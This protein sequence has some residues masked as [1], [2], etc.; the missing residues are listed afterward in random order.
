MKGASWAVLLVCLA[1][2]WGCRDQRRRPPRATVDATVVSPRRG[3][4][5]AAP[6]PVPS[7]PAQR[8]HDRLHRVSLAKIVHALDQLYVKSVALQG[9]GVSQPATQE[10]WPTARE[11]LVS[12]AGRVRAQVL[13]VDPLSNRSWAAARAIV[14]LRYLTVKLPDAIRE[15]WRAR[16]SGA[17]TT[18]KSDFRLIWSRLRRYVEDQLKQSSGP[19]TKDT[20]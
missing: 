18:W 16:P 4:A 3:P 10:R 2:A 7:T 20:K 13:A 11:G 17:F 12:E 15:S 19:P 5:V 14:L 9:Q 1:A 8:A 6:R